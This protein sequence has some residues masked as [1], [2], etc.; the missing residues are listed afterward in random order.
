MQLT[1]QQAKLLL[2]FYSSDGMT[3]K[4]AEY[5][6]WIPCI[7]LAALWVCH[8]IY[9]VFGVKTIRTDDSAEK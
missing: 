8:V 2:A 1:E 6:I 3:L 7:I 9:L 5:G 4:Y